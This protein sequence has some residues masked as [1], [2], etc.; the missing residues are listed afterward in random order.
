MR[1]AVSACLVPIIVL[2]SACAERPRGGNVGT[3]GSASSNPPTPKAPQLYEADTMVLQAKSGP[4]MLCLGGVLTSLPPQCGDVPIT[5]WDWKGLDGVERE[6]GVTWG[7]YHV[8]G[9]YDGTAFTVHDIGP[10]RP[11]DFREDRINVPCPEPAG[12]WKATDP[13]RTG[14]DDREAAARRAERQADFAGLWVKIF[15]PPPDVDVYGPDDV[16]LVTAF[17]GDP[18]RH[19]REIA[20]VWG[21][22]LCVTRHERAQADLLRIR[23]ELTD[24]STENFGI[25]VLLANVNVVHNRVEITA[26]VV[27]DETRTAIDER[28]GA[29]V[30]RLSSALKPLA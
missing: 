2:L 21:G 27:D 17:T 11:P 19:R 22:P 20:E 18:E 13:T 5:N 10:F 8:E 6:M 1:R 25:R 4:A 12:G 23:D 3:M 9:T 15:N 28:Y 7:T 14:E 26:V 16:V 24:R 30:V 29:G